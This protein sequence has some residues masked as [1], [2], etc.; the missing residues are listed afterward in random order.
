MERQ[1]GGRFLRQLEDA[2]VGNEG[3]VRA[4][5]LE[6]A[7]VVVQPFQIAVPGMILTVT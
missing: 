1:V 5:V 2:Q 4:D 3:R 6:E 7:Q